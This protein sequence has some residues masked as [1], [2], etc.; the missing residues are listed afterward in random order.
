MNI[1]RLIADYQ[2]MM[3]LDNQSDLVDIVAYGN[4]PQQ[5]VVTYHVTGLVW[6]FGTPAPQKVNHHQLEVYLHADYPRRPP[7]LRWLTEIFHPNILSASQNGGVCI[8]NWSPAESLADLVVR[9]GEM[10]QYKDYNV[11]DVLDER[12]AD[13]ARRSG[14]Y[15]PIDEREID[16]ERG[17]A[18]APAIALTSE[19]LEAQ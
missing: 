14:Q 4:P 8:G 18:P 9:I 15:L 13:W 6:P 5:Y 19:D 2:K 11:D 7:R 10:V 17:P 16:A 1:R 3:A 12:A